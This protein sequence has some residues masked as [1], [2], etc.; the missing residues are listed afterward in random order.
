MMNDA[1]S[2]HSHPPPPGSEVL[3]D[4]FALVSALC[5]AGYTV[6]LRYL[7]PDE[8]RL[9]MP[10]FFGL[11]GLFNIVLMW[12]FGLILALTGVEPFAFPQGM[13][14]L[15]LF[16]NGLIGTVLSDYL[17]L[18]SV[19]LTSPLIATLGLSLTIPLA[20]LSDWVF[21][22]ASFAALYIVGSLLVILGFLVV[23]LERY[24]KQCMRPLFPPGF[25]RICLPVTANETSSSSSSSSSSLE[26][27]EYEDSPDLSSIDQSPPDYQEVY[28]PEHRVQ[29]S[30][31]VV[32][33]ED[34]T[35]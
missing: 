18:W 24:I 25:N 29:I 6:L 3:G 23:N 4:L 10:L 34:S 16:V 22:H 1:G 27:E 2:S 20:M 21:N 11:V 17:W 35:P 14:I 31:S 30:P 28:H 8:D 13:V 15:W 19:L 12:P 7:V 32:E 33:R 26:H 9:V 5:Y